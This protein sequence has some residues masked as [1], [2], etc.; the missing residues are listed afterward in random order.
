[1]KKMETSG[2]GGGIVYRTTPPEKNEFFRLFE[3][4]GWNGEYELDSDRLYL[5]LLASW[6]T[7]SAYDG[8]RLVGFGRMICD[9]IVHA[10]ILD[11]IVL[12]GF[13]GRGIGTGILKRLVEKCREAE[14]FDIQLFSAKDRAGFYEKNGFSR[15]PDNAPGM[16][17][18]LP[19][20]RQRGFTN[21]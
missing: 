9:G 13:Q 17:I 7:V 12:P 15:R 16:Q 21:N 20:R 4:T 18:T 3:T 1:V 2:A 19:R 14:I 10:L 6:H 5:A 11:M 8:N